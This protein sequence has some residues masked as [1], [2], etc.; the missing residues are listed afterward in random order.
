MSITQYS[1][2]LKLEILHNIEL[3]KRQ[4]FYRFHRHLFIKKTINNNNYTIIIKN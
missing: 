3:L 1:K 4:I 2:K